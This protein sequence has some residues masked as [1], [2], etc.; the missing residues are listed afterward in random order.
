M[1][2]TPIAIAFIYIFFISNI[3][4]WGYLHEPY[5]FIFSSTIA[6]LYLL[7]DS[8]AFFKL[9]RFTT[10]VKIFLLGTRLRYLGTKTK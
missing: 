5:Y 10:I 1:L 2:D 7:S 3:F 9:T 6:I 4:G 8:L